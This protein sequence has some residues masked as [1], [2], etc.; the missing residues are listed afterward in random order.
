MQ[1]LCGWKKADPTQ[2]DVTP[3]RGAVTQATAWR[4]RLGRKCQWK[5]TL[6]GFNDF[7]LTNMKE[8]VEPDGIFAAISWR[9]TC[10]LKSHSCW[11]RGQGSGSES[12][13]VRLRHIQ[14]TGGSLLRIKSRCV[15]NM[16][17]GAFR[18]CSRLLHTAPRLQESQGVSRG[19]QQFPGVSR[20]FLG[21]SRSLQT[22]PGI[23]S[24]FQGFPG[25]YGSLQ[26]FPG[27]SIIESCRDQ[28]SLTRSTGSCA[29]STSC[30]GQ[31]KPRGL[32][33]TGRAEPV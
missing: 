9:Q 11:V 32:T 6:S 12:D 28:N 27:V 2:G 13:D 20:G 25:L 19:F 30:L 3:L 1:R 26:R 5:W 23:T 22:S 7:C 15:L 17:S 10:F 29:F 14:E 33:G 18:S 8:A 16:F 24:S 21:V 31:P 4:R